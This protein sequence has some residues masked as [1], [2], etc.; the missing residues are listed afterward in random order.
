MPPIPGKQIYMAILKYV[1]KY[2]K[3]NVNAFASF[4]GEKLNKK[5]HESYLC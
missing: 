3:I 2:H 1:V 4:R 5:Q